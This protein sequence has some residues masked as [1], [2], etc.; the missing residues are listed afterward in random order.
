MNSFLGKEWFKDWQPLQRI[1]TFWRNH[2]AAL[3]RSAAA[4]SVFASIAVAGHFYVK[5]N[6]VDYYRVFVGDV[7]AGTIK[8]PQVYEQY[9]IDKYKQLQDE[10]P[11]LHRMI[12]TEA[13]TIKSE[14]AYK[15]ATFDEETLQNLNRLLKVKTIGVELVVDGKLIGIMKDKEDAKLVLE[16]VKSQFVPEKKKDVGQVS[17]LSAEPVK[18]SEPGTSEVVSAEFIQQ[19]ELNNREIQPDEVLEPEEILKKLITGDV[20]PTKY[21]VEPGDCV[22]CIAT[23]FGISR[24]LIYRNNPDIQ[25]DKLKIGQELDLTV[26]QP[27]LTV[28]T[29]ERLT[30]NQ[31]IQHEIIYEKDDTLRQGVTQTIKPGKNGLKQVTFLVT[32]VNGMA[33]EEELIEEHVIENPE[34]ELAKKGTKVIIGEGTG[35][36]SW[37][38]VSPKI[39]S[40]YGMRWG[41]M[42]K[43]ID[44]VSSNRNILASDNGVIT[45]A[46]NKGDGYGNKIIIDH[47]N[48]YQTIY[49]HMSK[50]YVTRG[51]VVEK[52][53]KI[54]Y[55]GD[56]GDSTGIHLHFEIIRSNNTE[57]PIKH[58][59]K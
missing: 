20:K 7:E 1:P 35:K 27:T 26:L 21:T 47:K 50:L 58:L 51:K 42:H 25:D 49:G 14:R 11:D 22:S 59:S 53:E 44:I 10:S 18:P 17:I 32:K 34:P 37:P 45:Y 4:L 54:G 39:T 57:N 15:A 3:L 41:A 56:T 36:F 6:M 31:E 9:I 5:A 8:D 40:S 48:G 29:V 43:G 38:V 13:V 28:K 30:E 23:K 24:Q 55:M 33:M 19:V 52:G 2:K 12:S 16:Q 46:G